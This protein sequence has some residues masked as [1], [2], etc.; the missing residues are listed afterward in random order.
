MSEGKNSLW[1]YKAFGLQTTR[2]QLVI[3]ARRYGA[4]DRHV[5]SRFNQRWKHPTPSKYQYVLGLHVGDP[6]RGVYLEKEVGISRHFTIRT[7]RKKKSLSLYIRLRVAVWSAHRKSRNHGTF[8]LQQNAMQKYQQYR[9]FRNHSWRIPE[10]EVPC[11]T[12]YHLRADLRVSCFGYTHLSR[13]SN[14]ALGLAL[15]LHLHRSNEG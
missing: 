15:D 13:I 9:L 7:H 8:F 11:L 12:K 5:S 6:N 10:K 4:S 14:S 1:K 2:L 3:T